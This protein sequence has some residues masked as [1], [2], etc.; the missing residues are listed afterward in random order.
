VGVFLEGR[1][2][3][4]VPVWE[5]DLD[6]LPSLPVGAMM[7]E[8]VKS[9]YR[10]QA[11]RDEEDNVIPIRPEKVV[12]AKPPRIWPWV[13]LGLFAME[14]GIAYGFSFVRPVFVYLGMFDLIVL[15]SYQAIMANE[16]RLE[17]NSTDAK[18]RAHNK[19]MSSMAMK[20]IEDIFAYGAH[21][22]RKKYEE[23]GCVLDALKE[24]FPMCSEEERK[25]VERH[26]YRLANKD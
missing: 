8:R 26:I 11:E 25:E 16:R 9:A 21:S 13:V 7:V 24:M 20:L 3:W 10:S 2:P 15:A 4:A 5:E 14:M 12:A 6:G 1:R 18:N 23:A 19:K 17:L 22:G